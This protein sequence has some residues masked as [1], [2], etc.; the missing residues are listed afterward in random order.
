M[1]IGYYQ[2]YPIYLSDKKNKKY[3]AIVDGSKVHFG[4]TR[5]R[6]YYDKLKHYSNLNHND[7][8]RKR[9]YYQRFGKTAT[10]GTA[11]WFSHNILW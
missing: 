5:Y 2:S 3:Y 7:E 6:Q 10:K 11:K 8:Q 1:L 4:D 9:N